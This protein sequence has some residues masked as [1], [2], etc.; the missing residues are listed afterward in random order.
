M[1]SISPVS[2]MLRSPSPISCHGRG[3]FARIALSHIIC[4]S[5]PFHSPAAGRRLTAPTAKHGMP[6]AECQWQLVWC[7]KRRMWLAAV[8]GGCNSV[9]QSLA[10]L[11]HPRGEHLRAGERCE[12]D[13]SKR[14]VSARKGAGGGGRC[15]AI[16]D[17]DTDSK[18]KG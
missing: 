4:A 15:S 12:C 8:R 5:L 6:T 14:T 17:N 18:V 9:S 2:Q 7:Q 11:R 1:W 10:C 16:K 13:E 3:V